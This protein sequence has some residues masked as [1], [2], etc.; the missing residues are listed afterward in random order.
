MNYKLE[1]PLGSHTQRLRLKQVESHM[2]S[3]CFCGEG[4]K[5]QNVFKTAE[6]IFIQNR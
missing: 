3:F 6:Y 5:F 4:E 1:I 2:Q